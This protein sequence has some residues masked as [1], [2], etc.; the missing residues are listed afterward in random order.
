MYFSD[1]EYTYG[2]LEEFH[3]VRRRLLSAYSLSPRPLLH[4]LLIE[5]DQH[6]PVLRLP[7]APDIRHNSEHDDTSQQHTIAAQLEA[8]FITD[9]YAE[10]GIL[11]SRQA[12][13]ETTLALQACG[14]MLCQVLPGGSGFENENNLKLFASLVHAA[15]HTFVITNPYFVPDDTLVMAIT[16][17]AQRGVDV[18]LINQVNLFTRRSGRIGSAGSEISTRAHPHTGPLTASRRHRARRYRR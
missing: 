15:R 4:A 10:T 8:A 14:D 17:A 5:L 13:P 12:A 7:L 6:V 18:T 11:L 9:W 1:R 3:S 2:P 16:S